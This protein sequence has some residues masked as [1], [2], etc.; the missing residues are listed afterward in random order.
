LWTPLYLFLSKV[1]SEIRGTML[2]KISCIHAGYAS[3]AG[4]L[5]YI[6]ILYYTF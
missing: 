4:Y 3:Y 5:N 1:N 2:E 6:I